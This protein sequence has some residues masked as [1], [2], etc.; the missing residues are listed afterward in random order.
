MGQLELRQSRSG[1][2]GK[3][4]PGPRPRFLVDRSA[5]IRIAKGLRDFGYDVT[6]V[7]G[8]EFDELTAEALFAAASKERRVLITHN[9]DFLDNAR[10]EP[11]GNPG[12]VVIR[13]QV[14]GADDDTVARCLIRMLLLCNQAPSWFTGKKLDFISDT[15]LTISSPGS[16]RR[17]TWKPPANRNGPACSSNSAHR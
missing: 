9:P 8:P 5:G 2:V 14:D 16:H 1:Q 12:I 3:S 6:F 7:G 17:Y 11:A 15:I 13:P 4:I 10:F